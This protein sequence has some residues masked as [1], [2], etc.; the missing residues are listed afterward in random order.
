MSN[1]TKYVLIAIAAIAVGFL[2]YKQYNKVKK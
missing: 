1:N 2:L